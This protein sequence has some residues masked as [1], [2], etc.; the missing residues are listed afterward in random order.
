MNRLRRLASL[1]VLRSV[2]L[3]PSVRRRVAGVLALR[4][5]VAATRTTTP[6]AVV[7]GELM[8]RGD[9]RTYRVRGSG[10]PVAIQHGRDMEALYEVL[11]AGEYEP[12]A[13]L[14][15]R[16]EPRRV[17]RVVD[18]G[19]NVGVFTTWARERWPLATVLAAEPAPDNLRVLRRVVRGDRAVELVAAAVGTA[20]GEI[21]FVDGRG[22]GSHV[23][24]TE[25][26]EET[27]TVPMV[28]FVP[29][30]EGADLVKMDIEGAE[31]P[32]LADPRLSGIGPLVLVMEYHRVGAPSLP[33]REAASRLLTKAGFSVGHGASN[34]WGH[35]TLWAWKD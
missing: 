7:A 34:H 25:L 6:V 28:D 32:I 3:E 13:E 35:G 21:G 23:A 17:R 31:W 5:L 16:L 12:P 1:P 10:R 9:V 27:T 20:D 8:H 2:L 26:Q 24:R 4:F 14:S 30:F 11:V 22:A 18:V 15:S 29:L 33:A 19:A